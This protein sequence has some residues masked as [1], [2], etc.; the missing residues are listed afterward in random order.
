MIFSNFLGITADGHYELQGL[1]EAGIP[2]GTDK[3]REG[4]LAQELLQ[5]YCLWQAI[6]VSSFRFFLF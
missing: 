2:N 6:D 3:S 4:Y 1:F 5:V